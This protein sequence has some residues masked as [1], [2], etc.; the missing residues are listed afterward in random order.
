MPDVDKSRLQQRCV[1]ESGRLPPRYRRRDHSTKSAIRL[2]HF[3]VPHKYGEAMKIVERVTRIREGGWEY[4][5]SAI[6]QRAKWHTYRTPVIRDVYFVIKRVAFQVPVIGDLI[7]YQYEYMFSPEHLVF[8]CEEIG[9]VADLPGSIVE[10]GCAWGRTT[11][12][13]NRYI[14][15]LGIAVDYYAIDTFSG[16]TRDDLASEHAQGRDYWYT[17]V[18]RGNSKARFDR[19]MR[20]NHV[21]RVTSFQADAGT[22]DYEA[23]SPFR[24][25]LI[26]VD[27]YRPVLMALNAI[28]DLVVPGGIIVIDDCEPGGK[29][30]GAYQ[31]LKEFTKSK[32][33]EPVI[34]HDALGII[35]KPNS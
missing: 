32:G 24:M 4:L 11:I 17:P 5:S 3:D 9:S 7:D 15:S 27:L 13:L 12:F 14:D 30:E 19:T 26:D 6:R 35:V 1:T 8:L 33:M 2:G 23:I 22:F 16:F 28:Y 20:R 25:V 18:F 10:V 21:D 31:A 34:M 29:W